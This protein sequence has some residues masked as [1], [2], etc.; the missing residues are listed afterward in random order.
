MNKVYMN[1]EE[2]NV[3][4]VVLYADADDG[5]LFFDEAKTE[6]V[7]KDTLFELY[8]LGFVV[9]FNNEYFR[10][11]SYKPDSDAAIV[12]VVS[13]TGNYSFYSKEHGE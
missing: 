7:D 10:P 1:A 4:T 11:V 9:F 13:D 2:K 6:K 8:Q 12:T 3:K 5:H